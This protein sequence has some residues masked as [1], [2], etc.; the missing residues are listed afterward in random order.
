MDQE[1]KKIFV[2]D[3]ELPIYRTT[4]EDVVIRKS[5]LIK[6]MVKIRNIIK[7]LKDSD[8]KISRKEESVEAIQQACIDQ[9]DLS[10]KPTDIDE[11]AADGKAALE[12]DYS[13]GVIE[14][15]T[16]FAELLNYKP[17]PKAFRLSRHIILGAL[18]PKAG[19]EVLYGPMVIYSQI[20][21]TLKLIDEQISSFDKPKIELIQ[22]I[23]T[24]KQKAAVEGPDVFE[25]LKK[26]VLKNKA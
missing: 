8:V 17:A 3:N 11:I 20:H 23:A 9:L 10:Y 4:I 24:G 2:L 6:E 7:I 26:A 16:L 25:S 15:L 22:Q 5:P 13:E 1:Q 18:T 14:S 12:R 21:G 19:D